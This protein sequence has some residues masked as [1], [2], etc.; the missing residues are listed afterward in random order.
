MEHVV[1]ETLAATLARDGA[2]PASAAASVAIDVARALEVAHGAGLVHRDVK[3]ANVMLTGGA[4]AEADGPRH[5]TWA[6]RSGPHRDIDPRDG[7]V[8]LAGAGA[9]RARRP[10]VGRLLGGCVLYEMLTGR[11]PF[12]GGSVRRRVSTR[13]IGRSTAAK[14]SIGD[15]SPGWRTWSCA[16]WRRI[17]PRGSPARRPWRTRSNARSPRPT[18]RHRA[19]PCRRDHGAVRAGRRRAAPAGRAEPPL[20]TDVRRSRVDGCPSPSRSWSSRCWAGS[21]P[22]WSPGKPSGPRPHPR[23]VRRAHHRPAP[24]LA[25]PSPS[26]SPTPAP[27]RRRRGRARGAPGRRGR[28]GRDGRISERGRGDREAGRRCAR[29]VQEGRRRTRSG[30]RRARVEDRRARGSRR[31]SNQTEQHLDRAL[32]DLAEA[33][34]LADPATRTTTGLWPSAPPAWRSRSAARGSSTSDGTS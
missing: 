20:A 17:R 18:R 11:R 30:A 26:P 2:L 19:H 24:P 7:R 13:P 27:R 15:P 6:R 33:M 10:S 21:P 12:G 29:E 3:P 16:R 14:P 25:E 9:R 31:V 23:R 5:R 22:R 1:G 34:F 4:H 28:R 8:R 32:Q